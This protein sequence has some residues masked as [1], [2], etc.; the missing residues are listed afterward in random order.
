[1][2]PVGSNCATL[3]FW[4]RGGDIFRAFWALSAQI[5]GP[6]GAPEPLG[7]KFRAPSHRFLNRYTIDFIRFETERNWWEMTRYDSELTK[8]SSAD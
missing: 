3:W 8:G 6:D 5:R 1:V 4:R 7:T 2:G